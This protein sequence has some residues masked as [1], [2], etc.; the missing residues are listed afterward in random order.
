MRQIGERLSI[1]TIA[2]LGIDFRLRCLRQPPAHRDFA[3]LR[4]PSGSHLGESSA[5]LSPFAKLRIPIE[6]VDKPAVFNDIGPQILIDVL[7]HFIE[8]VPR[9]RYLFVLVPCARLD[10]SI[11]G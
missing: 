3:H 2:K 4:L 8:G 7:I 5:F 11:E 10:K 1:A 9:N 6:T